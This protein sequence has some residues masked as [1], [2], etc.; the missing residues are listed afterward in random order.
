[1]FVKAVKIEPI[2]GIKIYEKH[3]V[4]SDEIERVLKDNKS[5]FKKVA[6]SQ[7]LAMGLADRYLTIFFEY[8]NKTKEA[9]VATAYPSSRKQIKSYKRLTR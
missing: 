4:L 3:S 7:Y 5:I 8:N 9:N 6:G 1:M 2:T